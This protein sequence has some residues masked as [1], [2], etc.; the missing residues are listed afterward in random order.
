MQELILEIQKNLDEN[1]KLPCKKALDLLKKYSKD[2]FQ[3][4]I[5]ELGIKISD[6]EL[7]QF[8]KLNKNIAKS[9]ILEKIETKLDQKRYIAC[10]DALEFMDNFNAADIRAT[11]R[12]YKI[13]VKHCELGCFKEKK[14]KKFNIK[15]KIWIENPDGKLLFGKGKTDILEL[16]GECGSISQAAKIL[17]INYKKAW[18][19]IQDLEENMKEEL[20]IAKKGRGS[21]AGSKLT[22][23][24]Y[25][26]IHNFKILQQ[27]VE[28]YTNKRFKEL[29]FKKSQ[30]KDKT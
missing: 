30:E 14:G 28:E 29:F 25:E 24:A 26:L 16:I 5:N 17:G 22:P 23:R 8:G 13:E 11:L 2:E 19:Y 27:D 1:N 15:N 7:G 3:K 10:K 4:V 20:I 9:E 21:D 12:A 6:C 18:L